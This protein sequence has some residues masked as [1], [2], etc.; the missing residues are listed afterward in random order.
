L[1][2]AVEH[3][4][5]GDRTYVARN[6]EAA[7]AG[8]PR[9]T[10]VSSLASRRPVAAPRLAKS[11]HYKRHFAGN[12]LRQQDASAIQRKNRLGTLTNAAA[13]PESSA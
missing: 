2:V 5:T 3:H 11:N 9:R 8:S 1:S 12:A 7:H 4:I 10:R 6:D 13:A